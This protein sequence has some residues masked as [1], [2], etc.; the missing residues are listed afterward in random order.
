MLRLRRW[1]GGDSPGGDQS[2]EKVQNAFRRGLPDTI[3]VGGGE[4][5]VVLRADLTSRWLGQVYADTA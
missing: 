5:T 4:T 3:L 1:R 2:I